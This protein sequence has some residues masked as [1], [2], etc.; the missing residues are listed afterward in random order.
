VLD[1]NR[2]LLR[3]GRARAPAARDGVTI[4]E[5]VRVEDGVTLEGSTI[6]PNVTLETG[7][8]VRGSVVRDAIVGERARVEGATVRESLIGAGAA[9]R[10]GTHERMVVA[11]DEAAPARRSA[12]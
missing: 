1:T 11:H 12:P 4:V 3:A 9:V 5:P 6:G 7:A 10:G 2:H 8:V